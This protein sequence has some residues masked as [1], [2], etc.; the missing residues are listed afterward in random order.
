MANTLINIDNLSLA[1]DNFHKEKYS[2][3]VIDNF[4]NEDVANKIAAEFF[5]HDSDLFN[6]NYDNQIELKRTCNIWDRFPASIYQLIT[7]L[8]STPFIDILSTYT[9]CNRLYSDPGIHGGGL[10]SY[11]NGGKLNPHVDYSL[12]P[13]LGLQRKYNL[14]IYITPNW[15]EEWGGE[16]GIWDSDGVAP[17]QLVKQVSP[18]FNRAVFFDTTQPFW[19]GLATP[20]LCPLNISRNSLAMYYLV[21]P[22]TN[23]NTRNRALFAPTEDQKNDPKVLDLIKRRSIANGINVEQWDRL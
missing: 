1:F 16:F 6:G 9:G 3:C 10:H 18:I 4:L 19:H 14:L 13:K 15:Q 23:T 21:D 2:H 8:N 20:V 7:Y 12:H 22:L 17:T 5:T 11:P